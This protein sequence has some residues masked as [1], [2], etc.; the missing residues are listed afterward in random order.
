M[1]RIAPIAIIVAALSAAPAYAQAWL[2][3]KGE[4]TVSFVVSD[5]HVNQHDLSGVRSPGSN[6]NTQSLLADVTYGIRDDLSITVSLPIVRARFL[7]YGTP[8]HPTIQDNGAYHT[9]ATDLRFD[10]RYSAVNKRGFVLTPFVTTVT[11]SHE[12]Q[13]FAHA[14]PGR[15]VH[16][17]QFG[18]YVGKTL[19][20]LL[21]GMFIQARYGYGV[22][23]R[24]LD[25][26]HNRSIY[27]A[28]GGYFMTPDVRVFGMVNGQLTHGGVN[29]TPTSRL[30]WP[31][32]MWL[33]HDRIVHESFT[34]VGGGIGWSVNDTVD[35]FGSYTKMVKALNTHVLDH[36]LMFG[37][38]FRVQKSALER[39]I[40][41]NSVGNRIARCA[42]QKGLAAKR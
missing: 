2:S 12:Y 37:V 10:L 15:R 8:P 11:P 28:E 16:E 41:S 6:I 31:E 7:S 32:E 3:S 13:Y 39:G 22:Q 18:T 14:A 5:S 34:N 35:V 25:I 4:T 9:T 36:A 30:T 1:A 26:S 21:P 29:L 24:F 27:S 23:E 20:N 38:S 19:D 17:L 33:N 42:C 40:V